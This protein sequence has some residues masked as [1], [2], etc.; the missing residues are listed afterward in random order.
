MKIKS[1]ATIVPRKYSIIAI[2]TPANIKIEKY[3]IRFYKLFVL[4]ILKENQ[5]I[6]SFIDII[7]FHPEP[8]DEQGGTDMA[9]SEQS[10]YS[11]GESRGNQMISCSI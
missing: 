8:E 1:E 2:S 9:V 11:S 7:Y 4:I 3:F 10:W 5:E 6:F